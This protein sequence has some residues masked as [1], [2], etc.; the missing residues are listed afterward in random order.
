MLVVYQHYKTVQ[1]GQSFE[2]FQDDL[3]EVV[4][5]ALDEKSLTPLVVYRQIKTNTTWVRTED[6]FYGE[7]VTPEGVV[8]RFVEHIIPEK[9]SAVL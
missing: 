7:V 9:E 8:P 6:E 5:H 2:D 3:Y 4:T 1:P